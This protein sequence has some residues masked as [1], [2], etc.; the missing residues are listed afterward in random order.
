[1]K[2]GKKSI[3]NF[4]LGRKNVHSIG[5]FGSK[6]SNIVGAIAPVASLAFGPEIGLPLEAGAM[7]GKKV[8]NSMEKK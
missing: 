2:I 3:H 8:F 1:M 7:L 6:A 5:K 4:S